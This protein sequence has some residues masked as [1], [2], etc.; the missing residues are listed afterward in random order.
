MGRLVRTT[1][2]A[3][4]RLRDAATLGC[5]RPVEQQIPSPLTPLPRGARE[6]KPRLKADNT[7]GRIKIGA[8][9]VLEDIPSEVCDYRLGHR[10]VLEWI[11]KEY[12]ETRPPRSRYPRKIQQL[13]LC[14]SRRKSDRF[15]DAS[16]FGQCGDG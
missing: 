12:K 5:L 7:T 13:L 6:V 3:A 4:S 2:D 1:D 10:S 9:T 14:R 15:A 16:L 11:L 8:V